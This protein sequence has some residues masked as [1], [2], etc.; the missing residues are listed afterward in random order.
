MNWKLI[1]LSFCLGVVCYSCEQDATT[2]GMGMLPDQ[3]KVNVYADTITLDAT[4]IKLDSI[5]A[6]TVYG[7]LGEIYE[8]SYGNFKSGYICQFYPAVAFRDSAID[9]KVDSIKL[10]IYYQSFLGDSLVPMEASVYPVVKALGKNYYTNQN[11]ADYCDMN[12]V[13]G[14]QGYTIRDMNISDSLYL[15]SGFIKTIGIRLSDEIGQKFYDEWRKPG[16][17]AF[18]SLENFIDFFPGLYVKTTYGTGNI[19]SVGSTY[20]DVYYNR[21]ITGTDVD[22]NDSIYVG[23]DSAVFNVTKEVIQLND[24]QSALDNQ[25]LLTDAQKTHIKTPAAIFTKIIVPI[26]EII[27]KM[28]D[29]KF[30]N[31]KFSLSVYP[32]ADNAYEFSFP[33]PGNGNTDAEGR[34]KKMLLVNADSVTTFFENQS[35]AD[36]RTSYTTTFTS[37][38]YTYNFNNIA[39]IVQDAMDQAPNKN[40]ELLVIPVVVNTYYSSSYGYIDYSTSHFL[41]PS[42]VSLRKDADH[43]K[44]YIVATDMNLDQLTP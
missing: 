25:L 20:I 41:E 14:R 21:L 33:F 24:Y 37:S 15:S 7:L 29:K 3:D 16:S 6:K 23:K 31:A 32:P 10:S 1:L 30:T 34:Y 5:Y 2:V 22:G 11:P 19:I 36:S 35:V 38:N 44:L 12:T 13:Y 40:L 28:S 42:A 4:T 8:P 43:L 17:N 18:S 39:N 9:H 26:P 27:K